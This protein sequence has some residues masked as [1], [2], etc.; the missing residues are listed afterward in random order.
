MSPR[1]VK[2]RGLCHVPRWA[3]RVVVLGAVLGC[4]KAVSNACTS[5]PYHVGH[6]DYDFPD[7]L[8]LIPS[9]STTPAYP[10]VDVRATVRYPAT[11][12]GAGQP[13]AGSARYPL[14]VFLHGNHYTCSSPCSG[15]HSCPAADRVPNQRGYDYLLDVLASW[16]FIAVSIDGFDVTEAWSPSMTDYEARG[17]LILH[18]LGRWKDW[19]ALGT[20]PWGGLFRN[21]VD[22]TRIGLSGHS[23]G[24]EG[25]V[26]A[27]YI[28][29][30]EGLGFHI[31]AVNAIAPTDQDFYVHYV[32]R[33]PYFLLLAAS[34]GDVSNLQGLRTYD[35]TSLVTTPTQSEKAMAWVY[36]A[37]HN[38]FNT[39]W[40]P[41]SG[42]ACATDDGVGSGRL[43][44][45]VQRL[46]AC[47][48]IVPFFMLH[49]QNLTYFRSLFRGERL[50]EGLEGVRMYWTYQDPVR[51][52]VDNFDTGDNP[53]TNSLGGAVTTSG[54]FTTFDEYEFKSGGA[55]L[56]NSSFYHF[57]HG[58]VLGYNSDQTYET[59]LPVG[60]RNV[61]GYR[62]LSMRV[63]QILDGGILNPVDAPRTLRVTLRTASGTVANVDFDV[64]GVQS[65]PY[66]YPDNGGKT[67]L[68]MIRVPLASFRHYNAALPLND[69]ERVVLQFQGS[70]LLAL[71]DIQ[72]TK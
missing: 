31:K 24:G 46:T 17:R 23:R 33:V 54:G 16:G 66:P 56:F 35:R 64:T 63:S 50:A 37:N 47:Q 53:S 18:H 28:N 40:T 8:N 25:V 43:S 45:S 55:D 10:N 42:H 30:V 38:F 13:V 4:A 12:S 1:S 36:G 7:A 21:R 14:V 2:R 68:G 3:A 32:P 39:V 51:L 20:D 52:E 9:G 49:L 29:R 61:S 70:G 48:T 11:A 59:V 27:E 34:D 65:V 5:G 71:D 26:A 19:D 15:S 69:I 62:V 67:V 41:N 72:F 58:L 22:M 57:T 60:Q 44:P 6:V